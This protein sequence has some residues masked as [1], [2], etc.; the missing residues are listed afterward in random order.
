MRY[1]LKGLLKNIEFFNSPHFVEK[2][3]KGAFEIND[4]FGY[5]ILTFILVRCYNSV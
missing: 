3:Y 5:D 4:F 2:S 1:C